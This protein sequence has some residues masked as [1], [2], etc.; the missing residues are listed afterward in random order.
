MRKSSARKAQVHQ[1][2]GQDPSQAEQKHT[3]EIEII[4]QKARI[5][6]NITVRAQ[7][8]LY[9]INWVY[10]EALPAEDE[11]DVDRLIAGD[12]VCPASRGVER[13]RDGAVDCV[14]VEHG[15]EAFVVH[16]I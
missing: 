14:H 3:I 5:T 8:R 1:N 9:G 13:A 2:Q 16:M 10:G 11:S 7:R 12:D 6:D 15:E 4:R